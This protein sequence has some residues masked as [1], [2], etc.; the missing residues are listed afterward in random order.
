MNATPPR[1]RHPSYLTHRRQTAWQIILP[2]VLGFLLLIGAAVLV[3]LA[4]FNGHGDTARWAEVS[5]M[6]LTLPV[7]IGGVLL[8]L[9]FFA[10]AYLIGMLAGFI[11]RYTYPVQK[12]TEQVQAGAHKVQTIGHKPT[13]IIPE[14]GRLIR[15]AF[16]RI[17]GG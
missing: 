12:F 1:P 17:R 9:L 2:V 6:W 5:T 14:I 8:T 3:S 16:N 13:L 7:M 11:P 10:L 4:T 15:M